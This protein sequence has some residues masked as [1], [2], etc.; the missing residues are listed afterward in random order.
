[1][2]NKDKVGERLK[3]TGIVSNTSALYSVFSVGG[4]PTYN[5]LYG[6]DWF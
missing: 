4:F 3:N 1:M 6:S 5:P 2:L